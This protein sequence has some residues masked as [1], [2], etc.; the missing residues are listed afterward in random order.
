MATHGPFH[1]KLTNQ[2]ITIDTAQPLGISELGSEL[3]SV[4]IDVACS[5]EDACLHR[6]D[7]RCIAQLARDAKRSAKR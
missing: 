5:L 3:V 4:E 2:A 1:C 7:T 6:F